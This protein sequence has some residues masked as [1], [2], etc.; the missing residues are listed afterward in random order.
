MFDVF[1]CH[2]SHDKEWVRQLAQR[3]DAESYNGR[4]LRAW[5][6][7]KHIQAGDQLRPELEAALDASLFVAVVLSAASVQSRWTSFE[8]NH[9]S[10]LHPKGEGIIPL[11][12]ENSV[13]DDMPIEL[14]GLVHIDFSDPSK[15]E[16]GFKQLMRVIAK[17]SL[18]TPQ[19]V[20]SRC[21]ELLSTALTAYKDLP[22]SEPT[23]ESDALFSY[24][25]ELHIDD[26]ETEGLLLGAFDTMLAHLET[27]T[28]QQGYIASMIIAE[29]EAVLLCQDS[30]NHR[31][32]QKSDERTHWTARVASAR[33][34]SKIAEIQADQVDCSALIR[35]AAELDK[36]RWLGTTDVSVLRMIQR[37]AG[38]ISDT[39]VGQQLIIA[40]SAG[41]LA[42]RRA[43]GG[44]LSIDPS[45]PGPW[46]TLSAM[47]ALQ[48]REIRNEPPPPGLIA[49]LSGLLRDQHQEV[50]SDAE[51]GA[52]R[53]RR[54]WSDFQVDA[55]MARADRFSQPVIPITAGRH[56]LP[57]GGYIEKVSAKNINAKGGDVRPQAIY[58][59][60]EE[61]L[62]DVRFFGCS[63]M[64]I[65]QQGRLSRQCMRLQNAQIPFAMI[66][67]EATDEL[68]ERIFAIVRED[69][70]VF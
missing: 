34:Q 29:C 10:K 43:A 58:C 20:K 23:P 26:P 9:F 31:L 27:L 55:P 16:I 40:L 32:T 18:R 19:V 14:R 24:I 13:R 2:S 57:F 61:G 36:K 52:E 51:E 39:K 37:A 35:Y 25:E 49:M 69:G 65:L 66:T 15:F 28:I 44:A 48:R 56:L 22:P 21:L 12:L 33:A 46:F 63:G 3:I 42:S 7:D 30:R 50:V 8:W 38:K 11:I 67:P 64:L 41:G 68:P 54:A 47:K 59:L 60:T 5:F 6:D 1:L 53:I 70:I 45:S 17:P 62:P 4:H